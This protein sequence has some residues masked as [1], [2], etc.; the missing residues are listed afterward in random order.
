MFL[1]FLCYF[2]SCVFKIGHFF[3]WPFAK[4]SDSRVQVCAS[5]TFGNFVRWLSI[6]KQKMQHLMTQKRSP[7]KSY[8][9]YQSKMHIKIYII[10]NSHKAL[11]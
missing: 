10:D 11:E 5:T 4:E 1:C 6:S 2:Y 8:Q 3:E 7:F 9:K